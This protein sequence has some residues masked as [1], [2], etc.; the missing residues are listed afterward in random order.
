MMIALNGPALENEGQ[1]QMLLEK[2][3][4]YWMLVR[5]RNVRKSYQGRRP[6]APTNVQP[7]AVE[8]LNGPADS[9]AESEVSSSESEHDVEGSEHDVTDASPVLPAAVGVYALELGW[10]VME[11]P[12]EDEFKA[13]VQSQ[14]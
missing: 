6:R 9:E 8:L 13:L 5:C 4:D 2:V 12:D 14:F 11:P 1:V 3:F 7:S 10:V